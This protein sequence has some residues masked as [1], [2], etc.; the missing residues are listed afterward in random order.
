MSLKTDIIFVKALQ[1][2]A[3]LMDELPAGNVYNTAIALPDEDADNAP[4]PYIIVH[5][6]GMNN[7]VTTKDDQYEGDIDNVT[8]GIT[9]AHRNREALGTMMETIRTTIHDYFVAHIDDDTDEDFDLIPLDYTP[10]A[11]G[12]QYDADKPC[13]FQELIYN[14]ETNP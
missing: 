5:F 3:T 12:V 10:S 13:H 4:V 2:N 9:V 11:G 7:D 14:C 1:S 8:I 6:D